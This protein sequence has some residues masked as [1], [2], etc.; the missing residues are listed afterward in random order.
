[1]NLTPEQHNQLF[2]LLYDLE[3][4]TH[5][6]LDFEMSVEQSLLVVNATTDDWHA[7]RR[8]VDNNCELWNFY[9]TY[10]ETAKQKSIRVISEVVANSF[11]YREEK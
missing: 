1:M 9:W 8:K 11:S 4:E 10:V 5:K 2:R 7:V 6:G 3:I